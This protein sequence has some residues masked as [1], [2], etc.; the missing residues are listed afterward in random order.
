MIQ[1]NPLIYP[2]R[3]CDLSTG[4]VHSSAAISSWPRLRVSPLRHFW[5]VSAKQCLRDCLEQGGEGASPSRSTAWQASFRPQDTPGRCVAPQ[6][7]HCLREGH[8]WAKGPPGPRPV[9]VLLQNAVPAVYHRCHKDTWRDISE[10]V[11]LDPHLTHTERANGSFINI[12]KWDHTRVLFSQ[13]YRKNAYMYL[14]K[15][16]EILPELSTGKAS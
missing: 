3:N 10:M 11:T 13:N 14:R 16:A 4:T 15:M 5:G 1:H 7:H 2:G 12:K 6:C 8:R 9:G